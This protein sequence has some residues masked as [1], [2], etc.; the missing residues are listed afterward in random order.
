MTDHRDL[1]PKA[2]NTHTV[3]GFPLITVT[4]TP[5]TMGC[6]LGRRLKPQLQMLAQTCFGFLCQHSP[7]LQHISS[8]G[9]IQDAYR[10]LLSELKPSLQAIGQVEPKLMMEIEGL[11]KTSGLR[12]EE[13]VLIN[14]VNDLCSRYDCERPLAQSQTITLSQ[15]QT[16]N[17]CPLQVLLWH[18]DTNL[19]P[20]IS[21]IRRVPDN[22]PSTLTIGLAGLH[23]IAGISENGICATSNEL[24]VNDGQADGIP[25]C[26]QLSSTL[27][28]PCL[29]D[30]VAR[31]KQAPRLGGRAFHILYKDNSRATVEASGTAHGVLPDPIPQA[32]RVHSNHAVDAN[33]SSHVIGS[34]QALSDS[35]KNLGYIA[36]CARTSTS[37]R[38]ASVTRWFHP[39]RTPA[40]VPSHLGIN[41]L[42]VLDPFNKEF[43][44]QKDLGTDDIHLVEL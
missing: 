35:R 15:Q 40:T 39:D 27:W 21:I 30:A 26:S 16:E 12:A 31:L 33:V 34:E 38:A 4:G 9:K 20:F 6:S 23:S 24:L 28:S 8:P 19:L 44:I 37:V 7:Q 13:L 42:T 29:E 22:A 17:S 18:V 5:Y 25:T 10:E 41:V 3:A 11:T 36:K 2:A 32:P 14:A 43:H 1:T